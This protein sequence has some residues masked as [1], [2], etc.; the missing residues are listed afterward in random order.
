MVWNY[1]DTLKELFTD[2]IGG[3]SKYMGKLENADAVGQHGSISCGDAILFSIKLKKN[4]K[5]PLKD[6]IVKARYQTFGCTSAIASSEALCHIVESKKMTPIEALEVTSEDIANFL[7]GVP[8][9]KLH[10]SIMGAEVLRSTIINWAKGR[11]VDISSYLA[12]FKEV[13]DESPIICECFNKT[14]KYIASHIHAGNLANIDEIVTEIKVGGACGSCIDKPGGLYD[15]W[16]E[17]NG[18]DAIYKQNRPTIPDDFKQKIELVVQS[19]I[20][21]ELAKQGSEI[22]II[23]IKSNIVYCT[24]TGDPSLKEVVQ[25]ILKE[26]VYNDLK[27]I[28]I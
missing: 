6:R 9:Q 12:D 14:R 8:D 16:A 7:G 22:Q 2:A 18:M 25:D 24:I 23:E 15:I 28:D 20:R 1:T 17:I 5:D 13:S 4:S 3:K 27:V 11:G 26:L 10:C 19:A 21:P